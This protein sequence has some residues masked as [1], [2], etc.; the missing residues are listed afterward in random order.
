MKD[1]QFVYPYEYGEEKFYFE[2]GRENNVVISA[3]TPEEA[4]NQLLRMVDY[5]YEEEAE[6]CTAVEIDW[7]GRCNGRHYPHYFSYWKIEDGE[8]IYGEPQERE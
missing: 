3:D 5:D 8:Y 4:K 2:D 1:Y 7:D 6:S